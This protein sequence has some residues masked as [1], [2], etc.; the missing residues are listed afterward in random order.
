MNAVLP[1]LITAGA[2]LTRRA[3]TIGT[4]AMLDACDLTLLTSLICLRS[5]RRTE[6]PSTWCSNTLNW[7][8]C[9]GMLWSISLCTCGPTLRVGRTGFL[10]SLEAWLTTVLPIPTTMVGGEC[11]RR[12]QGAP[13]GE[14]LGATGADNPLGRMVRLKRPLG[15]S[16]RS[17]SADTPELTQPA[18]RPYLRNAVLPIL[19][20]PHWGPPSIGRDRTSE[21]T[22]ELQG[23]R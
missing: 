20:A 10:L 4:S 8:G 9:P 12:G 2:S 17:G 14:H 15:G 1:I 11:V 16:D 7:N 18:L 19:I 6:P 23:C 13:M 21:Q 22:G 5:T 3:A